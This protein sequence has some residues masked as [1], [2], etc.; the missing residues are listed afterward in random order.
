MKK[1]CMMCAVLASLAACGGSDS[2]FGQGGI[3]A[4]LAEVVKVVDTTSE[5]GEPINIDTLV[6]TMPEDSEP[7]ALN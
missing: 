2:S 7:V 4:F 1:L 5:T 6:A 3:D